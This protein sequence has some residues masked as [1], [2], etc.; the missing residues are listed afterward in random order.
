[1]VVEFDVAGSA[2][3]VSDFISELYSLVSAGLTVTFDGTDFT[4]LDELYVDNEVCRQSCLLRTCTSRGDV[5]L[6]SA[7]GYCN[8]IY[9]ILQT[10]RISNAAIWIVITKLLLIAYVTGVHGRRV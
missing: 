10:R 7:P 4:T 8:A 5:I 3:D 2:D 9:R 1:M 6:L